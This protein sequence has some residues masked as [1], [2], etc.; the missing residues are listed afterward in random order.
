MLAEGYIRSFFT[1]DPQVL[2]NKLGAILHEAEPILAAELE[3]NKP[4]DAYLCYCRQIQSTIVR[5]RPGR[6]N[7]RR[8]H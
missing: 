7:T 2:H 5:R 1:P 3:P 6:R 4:A 8:L